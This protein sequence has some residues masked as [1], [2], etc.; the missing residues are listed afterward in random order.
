M[1]GLQHVLDGEGLEDV[2]S[3]MK[4]DFNERRLEA[5]LKGEEDLDY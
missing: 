1:T 5:L 4:K 3:M 2:I